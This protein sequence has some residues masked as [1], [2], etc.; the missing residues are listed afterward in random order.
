[1]LSPYSN[2]A[3]TPSKSRLVHSTSDALEILDQT[4]SR[5]KLRAQVLTTQESTPSSS[6]KRR[7]LDITQTPSSQRQHILT[8][9][10]PSSNRLNRLT[11]SCLDDTPA[12]LKRYSEPSAF[13]GSD[14]AL[15]TDIPYS[16]PRMRLPRKPVG[17]SLSQLVKSLR[18][19]EE[20]K[21]DEE[22]AL[23][24]ELETGESAPVVK[25]SQVAELPLG[26][27]GEHD[28]SEDEEARAGP[29]RLWKKKGQ[30]RTTRR[31]NIG[32]NRAK[33]KPE[34]EW[35]AGDG[36]DVE[37]VPDTQ[38]ADGQAGAIGSS[39]TDTQQKD[40][41]N[42]KSTKGKPSTSATAPDG[43]KTRKINP[44]ATSHANFRSLKIRNKNTKGRTGG[45]FGRR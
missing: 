30:K 33:W 36:S 4:P 38:V 43:K 34:T 11:Q 20:E 22:M 27:D 29:K 13:V 24:H 35:K 9:I 8:D 26:A 42:T 32:V 7:C 31:A 28:L 25:D 18:K 41:K 5:R 2:Q 16:P 10:T 3:M 12:F 23:M 6:V 14:N 1:M 15:G 40:K 39:K 21:L 45:R 44:N 17:R 37:N 19:Q